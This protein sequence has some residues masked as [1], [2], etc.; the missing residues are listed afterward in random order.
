MQEDIK[1]LHMNVLNKRKSKY[2]RK[3]C[4]SYTNTSAVNIPIS[5]I[6]RSRS[7][8]ISKDIVELNNII[9][10]LD[11]INIYR[12]VHPIIVE[13]TFLILHET[14]TETDTF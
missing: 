7:Q 10:H 6:D 5:L 14:M 13:F 2:L 1:I 8:N 3:S 4:Q 12:I 9:N 11:L